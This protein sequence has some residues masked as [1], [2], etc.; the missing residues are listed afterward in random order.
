MGSLASISIILNTPPF[1]V[2]S[3]RIPI[4]SSSD[5]GLEAACPWVLY[6]QYMCEVLMRGAIGTITYVIRGERWS[7]EVDGGGSTTAVGSVADAS[8]GGVCMAMV[9]MEFGTTGMVSMAVV[10][11]RLAAL[12]KACM[13]AAMGAWPRSKS[14]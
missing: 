2:G 12:D 8:S 9:V 14:R 5:G 1:T 7:C 11:A 10:A 13:V 6:T 4:S 3:G